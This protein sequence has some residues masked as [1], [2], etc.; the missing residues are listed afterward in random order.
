MRPCTYNPKRKLC[1]LIQ[2]KRIQTVVIK[3]GCALIKTIF[4]CMK[5]L[6]RNTAKQ[7]RGSGL[8]SM[9]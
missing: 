8:I 2:T 6:Y 5:V 3:T 9:C 4:C 1:A 7:T